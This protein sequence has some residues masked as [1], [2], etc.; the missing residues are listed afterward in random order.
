MTVREVLDQLH[1][2]LLKSFP[3][4]PQQVFDDKGNATGVTGDETDHWSRD[5]R[6]EDAA[7][8]L[9]RA[10]AILTRLLALFVLA[11]LLPRLDWSLALLV[12]GMP[13]YYAVNKNVTTN[14]VAGTLSTHFRFLTVA[15][16]KMAR[17]MGLSGAARFGT[18]G[19][20]ILRLI[21]PGA[22][23]SGGTAHTPS[24]ANPDTPAADTTVF[25]D[26]SAIT[27]GTSPV[28]VGSVGVA[29]TGGQG[30]WVALETDM[31][32]AMKPNG[33]ANGNL[34]IA[35]VANAASVSVDITGDM[36]EN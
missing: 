21:R 22:A 33:G 25:D 12:F 5:A 35:S 16:Q 8:I 2:E 18:A 29:Q 3:R 14:G 17:I 13:F 28:T 34:E 11:V 36:Q 32:K 7:L 26:T 4:G 15:N 9:R 10:E 23:G 24:E 6:A 27:A 20:A 19:G 1:R 30:G 31:G